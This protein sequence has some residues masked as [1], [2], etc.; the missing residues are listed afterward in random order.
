MSAGIIVAIVVAV[1][2]VAALVVCVMAVMRRRRLQPR[3]GPEYG[4]ERQ[5]RGDLLC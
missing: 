2:V 5:R 3:F 1:I 4:G